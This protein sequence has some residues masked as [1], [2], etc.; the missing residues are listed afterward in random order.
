MAWAGNPDN[1]R[2]EKTY[3]FA[4]D[5][6]GQK[7]ASQN[8]NQMGLVGGLVGVSGNLGVDLVLLLS[9]AEEEENQ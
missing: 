4:I 5:V 2:G 3:S 9:G 7:T 8:D 6:E 1:S